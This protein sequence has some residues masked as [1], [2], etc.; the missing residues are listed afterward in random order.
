M[1]HHLIGKTESVLSIYFDLYFMVTF[2]FMEVWTLF[3]LAQCAQMSGYFTLPFADGL[4][5]MFVQF[6]LAHFFLL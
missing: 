3:V 1:T 4:R 6:D 2:S 5:F